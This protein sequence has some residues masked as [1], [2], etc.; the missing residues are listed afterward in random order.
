MLGPMASV[1]VSGMVSNG[2]VSMGRIGSSFS[3]SSS[4]VVSEL[5]RFVMAEKLNMRSAT[6]SALVRTGLA[7]IF[8][9]GEV[10]CGT[11]GIGCAWS[12]SISRVAHSMEGVL[13]P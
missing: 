12:A 7:L 8:E 1:S 13:K 6:G 3:I 11:I 4:N 5:A 9:I 10:D 2:S